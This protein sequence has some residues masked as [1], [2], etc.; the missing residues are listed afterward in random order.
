V[1]YSVMS[2]EELALVCFQT[3]DEL[4]WSEFV[5]RFHPLIA[6]VAIRT[7]RRWRE[8]SPQVIDDLVQ[9]VYLKLYADRLSLSH[10]FKP[11][12]NDAIF[13]YLKVFTANLVHDHFKATHAAKRGSG[14]VAE[15]LEILGTNVT[16]SSQASLSNQASIE[17]A[18][19]LQE[20]DQHLAR[21]I[22]VEDLSRSRLI[23]WLYY[24]SGLS[25]SAIASLPNIGLTTKGVESA[26]LRLTRGVRTALAEPKN[27]CSEKP[28]DFSQDQKGFRQPDSF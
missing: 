19:L 25:A 16:G 9:D 8:S 11:S 14:E 12:H 15:D 4:A 10:R 18:I 26:L 2:P 27:E 28:Q 21:S 17:R 13:G 6:R 7:A 3:G 1:N 5:R 23:F 20:I 22:P 24:R